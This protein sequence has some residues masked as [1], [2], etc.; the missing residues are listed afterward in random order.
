MADNT[1]INITLNQRELEIFELVKDYFNKQY[2]D[3]DVSNSQCMR[4]CMKRTYKTLVE[5][6]YIENKN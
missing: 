3:I 2:E 4:M 5:N 6:G 1:Q